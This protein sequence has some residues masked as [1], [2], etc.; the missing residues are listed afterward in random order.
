MAV[1]NSAEACSHKVAVSA[2]GAGSCW[3]TSTPD[4]YKRQ[5]VGDAA[6]VLNAMLP[7]I[8]PAKHPEWMTMIQSWQAQD[9]LLYTSRCV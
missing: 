5:I 6:Y 2:S 8:K 4:V 1:M 9:C 3:F 7:Q